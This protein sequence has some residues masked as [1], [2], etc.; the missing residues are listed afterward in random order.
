MFTYIDRLRALKPFD[1]R[2]GMNDQLGQA[3]AQQQWPR[4]TKSKNTKLS[5]FIEVQPSSMFYSI[6]PSSFKSRLPN[7]PSL[8]KSVGIS[9]QKGRM[10]LMGLNCRRKP[11]SSSGSSITG[12]GA[13][14]PPPT[15]SSALTVS[16]TTGAGTSGADDLEY[17][18]GQLVAADTTALSANSEYG[19]VC[20]FGVEP[21][22]GTN[23]DWKFATQG[24]NLL[25]SAVEES[26]SAPRDAANADPAFTRQ[27]YI[28]SMTYL[29]RGLPNDLS[30]EERVGLRSALPPGV[31]DPLRL[32]IDSQS[33]VT[34][35]DSEGRIRKGASPPPS[36]LH[37]ILASLVVQL[38]IFAHFLLPHIKALLRNAYV[39]ERHNRISE[40]MLAKSID[41]VD[42]VGKKSIEFGEAVARIGDGK[43]GQALNEM[44]MWC[45]EGV[46]GGI[47]EGVGEGWLQQAQESLQQHP[48]E[49]YTQP[50]ES[51]PLPT[52]EATDHGPIAQFQQLADQGLVNRNIIQTITKELRLETMTEVQSMTIRDSL[53]GH[54]IL[55]QAKTGTGKTIAFLLPVIQNILK[56]A[57]RNKPQRLADIRALVISPTRELAEQIAAEAR[58]LCSGTNIKVRTAVGGTGKR[59]ALKT[60]HTYG[61][62]LLI[63]TPGRLQDILSDPSSRVS[64]PNLHT[65]VLDEADRLLDQ[66]F[67]EAIS[68]IQKLLP[69]RRRV[70]RQTLL[71]SATV[72]DEVMSM[73]DETL[74]PHYK[75]IRTVKPGEVP[76]H[77]RVPQK[78]VVAAG[79]ENM[80]PALLELC[81]RETA[82]TT[83]SN[84]TGARPFKAI[85]YFGS[86]ANVSY[87][88]STFRNLRVSQGPNIGRNPISPAKIIEMHSK[89]PQAG[90][91]YASE[92]F[93]KSKSAIL[94][95]SDVTARGMDFPGV[96]HIIQFGIPPSRE[97]YI[98]RIGRTARG[99]DT[100]EGWTV[101]CDFEYE[102]AMR[103]LGGLPIRPDN[104][105]A[106]ASVDMTNQVELPT[107]VA[108]ILTQVSEATLPVE[109]EQK[110]KA[111]LAHL[112]VY[113]GFRNK[114]KV[115][116]ALNNWV[117]YGWGWENPPSVS[118][119]LAQKMGYRNADGLNITNSLERDNTRPRDAN[120]FSKR[121]YS[122]KDEGSDGFG[123]KWSGAYG[124]RSGFSR[125]GR[126][127]NRESG[128][129]SS[130]NRSYRQEPSLE[131]ASW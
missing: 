85:V 59:F 5:G 71:Y 86:T 124:D 56:N 21:N 100:G 109:R 16:T 55:A 39:Y 97:Q 121:S 128:R 38:F 102:E 6:L 31:A 28:H 17:L 48:N 67:A 60:L 105:L 14:T 49:G 116:R 34:I 44:A 35:R 104:S 77:D 66:G 70:D 23:I 80:L 107:G 92:I 114:R 46:A 15:Y 41:T 2:V 13:R 84:S 3:A 65:L 37:R 73:V 43:L 115:V 89:L 4:N 93:R 62:D 50:Y 119:T 96:T 74:K 88:A 19:S 68:D 127:G 113:G 112:G 12:S 131:R 61:C 24:R 78:V 10:G 117:Q 53:S 98:H 45:A 52:G 63:G 20:L 79:F 8:R 81:K 110:T 90:R 1:T 25:S 91:M 103:R 83:D 94:F 32:D 126:F 7:I 58:K 42:T 123:N 101:V 57:A 54:D 30:T 75:F 47:Y 76:T 106:T 22:T 33:V 64:V 118:A 18:R 69:D 99:S 11:T 29:L 129:H 51:L 120:A 72:P 9:S 108:E 27:L 36:L 82:A 111:Y 122:R 87:A 26:L 40:K 125:G 95:S 130:R